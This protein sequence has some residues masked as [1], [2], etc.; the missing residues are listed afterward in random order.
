MQADA[1]AHGALQYVIS[2]LDGRHGVPPVE[3]DTPCECVTLGDGAFWILR[4]PREDE[5]GFAFGIVDESGK[6]NLNAATVDALTQLPN[7]TSDVAGAIQD[8]RDA[9]STVS[10]NGAES[11]AYLLLDSPYTCKDAPFE[12]VEE[13]F[14]VK[15]VTTA[16]MFGQ[17]LN[18]NGVIDASETDASTAGLADLGSGGVDRGIWHWVTV[19][20]AEPNTTSTGTPRVN[21][22]EGNEIGNALRQGLSQERANEVMGMIRRGRPYRNMI[23][24]YLRSGLSSS[25]FSAVADQLTA[26]RDPV[27]SGMVNMATAPRE[28]LRCL[29]GLD[30]SDAAALIAKRAATATDLTNLAWVADALSPEKAVAVGDVATCRSY[31]YSA[32]ILAVSGDGRAFKR[33]RAVIDT[34]STPP[35]VVY[36]KDMTGLGWPLSSELRASL[37]QGALR[38]GT[39]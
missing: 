12:S 33:Y 20:S 36:W 8:W 18:R 22:N 23:D 13:L 10:D 5:S 27:L 34:R 9:D 24:F 38:E 14:L 39:I 2:R 26:R 21:V 28:V 32:D 17:D 31:Q 11:E 16:L 4:P 1:I 6:L 35:K 15:G 25:E 7:M 3:A 29:P 19:Y 37:R 30:D